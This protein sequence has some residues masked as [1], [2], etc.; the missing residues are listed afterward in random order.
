[1]EAKSLNLRIF[2]LIFNIE[3]HKDNIIHEKFDIGVL[4]FFANVLKSDYMRVVR[5]GFSLGIVAQ[6]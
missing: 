6:W 2:N 5:L 3:M 1:M 4:L